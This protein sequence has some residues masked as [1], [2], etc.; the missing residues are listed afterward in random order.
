ME[1]TSKN[2]HVVA[3]FCVTFSL[4]ISKCSDMEQVSRRCPAHCV[5]IVHI[6]G[7]WVVYS[8][9]VHSVKK[10]IQIILGK[11]GEYFC[12]YCTFVTKNK[13]ELIIYLHRCSSTW[14]RFMTCFI[15]PF[16]CISSVFL[17]RLGS[18]CHYFWGVTV[19]RFVLSS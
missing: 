8:R 3:F 13:K 12:I 6:R 2:N 1:I 17:C 16:L 18:R 11:T 4:R 14:L 19:P 5:Y 15:F 7:I 10:I 9:I